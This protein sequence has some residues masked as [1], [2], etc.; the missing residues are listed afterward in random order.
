LAP[1]TKDFSGTR[2]EV[3]DAGSDLVQLRCL[4]AS[5]Q[6]ANARFLRG[7]TLSG[8]VDLVKQPGAVVTDGTHWKIVDATPLPNGGPGLT[9]ATSSNSPSLIL[10]AQGVGGPGVVYMAWRALDGR[11]NVMGDLLGRPLTV[12]LANRCLDRPALAL[13]ERGRKIYLAWTGTDQSINLMSSDDGLGFGGK[14]TLPGRSLFGPA[15][16]GVN[17]TPLVAWADA[18]T[19]ELKMMNGPNAPVFSTGET[20]SGAPCLGFF[21]NVSSEPK[22][23]AWTGT[24]AERQ[25]NVMFS[26][27]G[28]LPTQHKTTL[29]TDGPNAGTAISGPSLAFKVG[30]DQ[31]GFLVTAWTGLPGGPDRGNHLNIIFSSNFELFDGRRTVAPTSGVGP[32]VVD[33]TRVADANMFAAWVDGQSSRINTAH[34]NGL[35]VIPA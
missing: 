12:S 34:Y 33:V 23:L 17:G 11:I 26:E 7:L 20:S 14:V 3:V 35:P 28:G 2:W 24:N 18:N 9:S 32:A 8:G 21:P 5:D 6:G 22:F 30:P 1:N 4:G 19:G 25:L 31:V 29:P 27:F 13:D 16:A 15:I 10:W